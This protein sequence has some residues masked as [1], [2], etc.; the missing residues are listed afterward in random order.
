MMKSGSTTISAEQISIAEQTILKLYNYINTEMFNA[1]KPQPQKVLFHEND[2]DELILKATKT[3][4][5]HIEA[6]ESIEL[7]V[8]KRWAYSAAGSSLVILN[9]LKAL[10][11]QACVHFV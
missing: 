11:W 2:E 1:S 4:K 9:F 5:S 8:P 3:Y 6:V 7:I 10:Q